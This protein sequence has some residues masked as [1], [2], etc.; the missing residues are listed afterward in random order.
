MHRRLNGVEDMLF[1]RTSTHPMM[2]IL[3][4]NHYYLSI[5]TILHNDHYYLTIFLLASMLPA[6]VDRNSQSN[7]ICNSQYATSKNR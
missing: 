4:N 7:T 1:I 6:R 2:T 3:R 5:M